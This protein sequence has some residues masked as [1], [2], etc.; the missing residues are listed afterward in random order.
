MLA[1]FRRMVGLDLDRSQQKLAIRLDGEVAH[2]ACDRNAA[3]GAVA[4][5][6]ELSR[7]R[8]RGSQVPEHFAFVA[9]RPLVWKDRERLLAKAD[10]GV[11]VVLMARDLAKPFQH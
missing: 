11:E 10:C 7:V 4:R 5:T 1:R 6:L 8:A 3:L 2:L 9:A